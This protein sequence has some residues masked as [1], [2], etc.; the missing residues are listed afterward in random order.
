MN[1]TEAIWSDYHTRL[2]GVDGIARHEVAPFSALSRN[3]PPIVIPRGA[4]NHDI[5]SSVLHYSIRR[6]SVYIASPFLSF[7]LSSM[8]R[9]FSRCI[10][11]D[12]LSPFFI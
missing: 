5:D 10:L 12:C 8:L 9:L 7:R 2:H 4:C 6:S 1:R 3:P 11:A